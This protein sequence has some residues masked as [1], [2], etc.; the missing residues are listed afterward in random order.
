M[1]EPTLQAQKETKACPGCGAIGRLYRTPRGLRCADC[2][3]RMDSAG[4][5]F[6]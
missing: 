6:L 2:V 5:G 4:L 1:V 3:K